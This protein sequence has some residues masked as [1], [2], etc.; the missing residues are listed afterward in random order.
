V[1]NEY[2]VKWHIFKGWKAFF[3][4]HLS[5]IKEILERYFYSIKILRAYIGNGELN[6]IW[7]ELKNE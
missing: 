2:N 1:S 4:C 3:S 7:K 6:N 5:R